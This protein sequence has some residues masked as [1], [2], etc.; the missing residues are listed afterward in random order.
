MALTT[1]IALFHHRDH[2]TDA[3]RDLHQAGIAPG[4]ITVIGD[5]DGGDSD[6]TRGS[7]GDGCGYGN[8]T[9][10]DAIGVPEKDRTHLEDGIKNGGVVISL[11]SADAQAEA[12]EKIFHTH[13][14]RKIDETDVERE[15]YVA[16]AVAAPV[17]AATAVETGVV[18][19][20]EESLVVGKREVDRGGVR[21]FRRVVEEPASANVTL[22]EEHVV[23]DRRPTDRAVTDADL[24]GGDRVIELTETAE[25]AVVSKT[26]RVVEEVRV[27]KEA[28]DHT[29][30]VHDTV[31]HTEVDFE[32]VPVTGTV[33]TAS[34]KKY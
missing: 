7:F 25:E 5:R 22:H 13:S 33:A 16:P 1:Y 30:T 8:E 17:V 29:E 20:V 26:A 14:T 4:A 21:V 2:A 34:T 9:G 3:L 18:P 15:K 19:I 28:T 31:R 24:L 10:L 27:G 11:K 23:V 6:E 32:E 12:V